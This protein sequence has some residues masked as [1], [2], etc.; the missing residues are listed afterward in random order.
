MSFDRYTAIVR[1]VQS[2]AHGPRSK[3]AVVASLAFIWILSLALATPA[4]I[5]AELEVALVPVERFSNTFVAS[6]NGEEDEE[7]EDDRKNITICYPF[8]ERFGPDYAKI[9]VLARFLIHY[10][11]PLIIIGT[12]Y[13]IT[14]HHLVQRYI[15]F[16]ILLLVYTLYN[17][18]I[19]TL[20]THTLPGEATVTV[21]G[22]ERR[23]LPSKHG[24]DVSN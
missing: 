13:A 23:L 12:L 4:L 17:N 6:A 7:V 10:L 3:P 1:P 22:I 9:V 16:L 21:S 8:P 11:I 5:S 24:V 18:N 15:F 20:S 19:Y 14:A 2:F